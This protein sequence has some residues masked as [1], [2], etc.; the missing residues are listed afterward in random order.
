MQS[1]HPFQASGSEVLGRVGLG[2]LTR[3]SIPQIRCIE[4][5]SDDRLDKALSALPRNAIQ[6]VSELAENGIQDE[7]VLDVMEQVSRARFCLEEDVEDAWEN[8]V[9]PLTEE[10]TLSQPFVVAS[11][12]EALCLEGSERVL[13]VG[14]GSGYTTA[15]LCELCAEVCAIEI[16]PDLVESS[17]STLH[18]LG[19]E[20]FE[21]REGDG[22]AGWPEGEEFDAVLISAATPKAPSALMRSL[23]P[24]GR[25]VAPIGGKDTQR[26]CLYEK[27]T[28]GGP[29]VR[30][31]LYRVV[32]VPLRRT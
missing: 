21:V 5:S 4:F 29:P 19:Y 10:A 13:D 14:S 23:A 1:T 8:E 2:C 22:W 24:G 30:T 26:L 16:D 11:M 20:N 28:D 9:L 32:F 31:H 15:L 17:R 25:L 27:S 12:L 6:L 18:S 7:A 3:S